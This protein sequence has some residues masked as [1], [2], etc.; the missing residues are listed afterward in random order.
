MKSTSSTDRAHPHPTWVGLLSRLPRGRRYR[1]SAHAWV[2]ILRRERAD[3]STV[4]RPQRRHEGRIRTV[5]RI[6]GY[7]PI[8]EYALVGDGRTAALI[9]RDGTVDW[10]CLPNVDSPSVFARVLDAERGGSLR[11]E[12]GVPYEAARRYQANSNVL[13]TTFTTA[14]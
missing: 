12:P 6:D 3:F 14:D 5:E 9:A 13:E 8:R 2:T 11:L 10:L 1:A 4:A 7:A